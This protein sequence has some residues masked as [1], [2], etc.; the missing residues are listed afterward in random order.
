MYRFLRHPSYLGFLTALAGWALV[1]RSGIGLLLT[2]SLVWPIV[3]RIRDEEK[4]LASE[5]GAEYET[6]RQSTWRLVP[7]I[8]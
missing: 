8:Y 3:Y 2:A 6:Y 1:F 7:F 4:L 5:F